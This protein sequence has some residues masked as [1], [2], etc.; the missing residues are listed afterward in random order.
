[1]ITLENGPGRVTTAGGTLCR[2]TLANGLRV[3]LSPHWPA[4]RAAV[5]VHYGVG[6][7]S[8]GPGQEGMAH[9]FEHLMFRGSE[10]V[11]AGTFFEGLYPL[12]GSANGT[13]HQDYTDY[14]QS[15]PAHAVEQ[16]LFREADRM[17]APRFSPSELSAQLY[18]V[19][20]EIRHMRDGRPYGG[21]PWPLLPGALFASF[22]N[23]HDG[24]GDP[25][26]LDRITVDDCARFFDAYYAPSN[27]VLTVVGPQAC[28]DLLPLVERH[29]GDIPDRPVAGRPPLDEP[30][31]AEARLLR[32]TDPRVVRTAVAVGHRTPDP[33]A[34]LPAY[35]AHMVLAEL[36]ARPAGHSL[37]RPFETPVGAGC[38]FFGPLDARSPDVL[39]VT[40]VLPPGRGPEDFTGRLA[41]WW[42]QLGDPHVLE[43]SDD[44]AVAARSLAARHRRDHADLQRRCRA[45]GRLEL[46][47]DRPELADEIPAVLASVDARQVAAAAATLAGAHPGILVMERGGNRT[48]SP[49]K[50]PLP[51]PPEPGR[52]AAGPAQAPRGHRRMPELGEEAPPVFD[53]AREGRL[54]NGL[55]VMAVP[56]RRAGTVEVRLRAS[57]GPAGWRWPRLTARLLRAADDAAGA[58]ARVTRLG[59]ELR[60][61]TDGQWADVSGWAPAGE[62]TALLRVLSDLLDPA[63][64]PESLGA[65]GENLLR[66]SPEHRMDEALRLHWLGPA[67]DPA[68]EA[69]APNPAALHRAVLTPQDA[70]LVV[71]G[72]VSPRFAVEEAARTL[73]GWRAAGTRPAPTRAP[74][75]A[76]APDFLVVREPSADALH[77]T[78]CAAEPAGA[79]REDPA[80]YLATALLGG[81]F[82][83]RLAQR[84]RRLRR[85]GHVMFAARDVVAD[86]ARALVRLT[87][88]RTSLAEAVEDVR[89]EVA[90][91]A[92]V[93]P[94]RDELDVVR[95]YCAAQLL[96]AFDSPGLLAD[97]LRHTMASGRGLD[98]VL[99]RPRLLG[100]VSGEAV[101]EAA[102]AVFVPVT[103]TVVALG[104]LEEDPAAVRE[105]LRHH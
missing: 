20:R 47:F 61:V 77:L 67:A 37:P 102:R 80:R 83:A 86:R 15:A 104:D 90:T 101:A 27:A 8:E 79:T 6:F 63:R 65:E 17:R 53:G 18:E 89:E 57:L 103:G 72:D 19:A 39:V 56:D 64:L 35:A 38:G 46:L 62:L 12:A 52:G 33:A 49:G 48:P 68:P 24:Y 73:G 40:S 3:V 95:R 58:S 55:R 30:E 25:E 88:P 28:E 51:P 4:P 87:V 78:L 21:F 29:F 100:E 7:R 81:H 75:A 16:M 44:V 22:A 59:G 45:L 74:S 105:A 54:D 34:G 1:V 10:N 69:T 23:A 43:R 42:A 97:A 13:T 50:S 31:P 32:R 98:W 9:L 91:L 26:L 99:R 60:L 41:E 76:E 66:R 84:C 85:A 14:F 36:T 11:P 93:P 96:T 71:V 92:A 94:H 5:C 2:H 70:V 82:G